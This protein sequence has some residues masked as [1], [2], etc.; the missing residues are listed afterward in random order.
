MA[1]S[2]SLMDW[3]PP[4]PE[5]VYDPYQGDYMPGGWPFEPAAKSA[6]TPGTFA[7][8]RPQ[9][10]L[11][12]TAK[13]VCRGL[14]S[15]GLTATAVLS[16]YTH[17][18][19]LTI[20]NIP[21]Y[22]V[23]RRVQQRQRQERL[24]RP[25]RQQRTPPTSLTDSPWQRAAG[26]NNGSLWEMQPSQEAPSSPAP[27][28]VAA[29]PQATASALPNIPPPNSRKIIDQF[30]PFQDMV[31]QIGATR[32]TRQVRRPD[33]RISK[34]RYQTAPVVRANTRR[35]AR[36]IDTSSTPIEKRVEE[37]TTPPTEAATLQTPY[38]EL[39]PADTTTP[40]PSSQSQED[41]DT[42]REGDSGTSILAVTRSLRSN[43][44]KIE[45]QGTRESVQMQGASTGK[46]IQTSGP[47]VESPKTPTPVIVVQETSSAVSA[48][49]Q[50]PIDTSLLSPPRVKNRKV[51][52]PNSST[53]NKAKLPKNPKTPEKQIIS[54]I[55]SPKSEFSSTCNISPELTLLEALNQAKSPAES[56]I[57][58]TC[59]VSPELTLLET[60]N[61]AKSPAESDISSAY[62]GTPPD[63]SQDG[64]FFNMIMA[65]GG[66]F[67]PER[68][69]NKPIEQVAATEP[70]VSE[71]TQVTV[72]ETTSNPVGAMAPEIVQAAAETDLTSHEQQG[73]AQSTPPEIAQNPAETTPSS[74]EQR[75]LE[76]PPSPKSVQDATMSTS[77][78][79]PVAIESNKAA[80]AEVNLVSDDQQVP[81]QSNE[82]ANV[83]SD[84]NKQSSAPHI[85]DVG[86]AEPSKSNPK[87]PVKKVQFIETP[88]TP[89]KESES[90][91]RAEIT[92]PEQKLA[93]LTLDDPY[94][95]ENPLPKASPHSS[96]KK[97]RITRA[98]AKRLQLLEEARNYGITPL[99]EEWEKKIQTALRQGHGGFKATDFTRVVPL[100]QGRGTDNWLNDEVINGYLKLVV[101]HGRQNDRPTQ[102][103]THHAFVSFFYNN[104]ESKGY[105]GVRRWASR[106][107]IGGKNLLETEQVFI[108]INS[109]MHWTLCVVSGK[110]KTITHYNSLGGNGRRYVQT[111]KEWVRQELGAAFKEEEWS[112]N[113]VGESPRQQNM[114]DCGVFTI[115]SARQIM[116]GLSPMSYGPEQ[117]LLQRRR[118]VAELLNGALLKSSE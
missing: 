35:P 102:V 54:N 37:P 15:L 85:E 30:V 52:T 83:I 2:S 31:W 105:D 25:R 16:Q 4:T 28:P 24:Q 39:K 43:K 40:S 29:P 107:K 110:N 88:V 61:Q 58:S 41:A 50:T 19:T 78:Q 60:L 75:A 12:P 9:T 53:R 6:P 101:A 64:R 21:T 70:A 67:S 11:L 20:V 103:P 46:R 98:E 47:S 36:S 68:K 109:G 44:R 56:D 86:K 72:S 27:V 113:A 32:T 99:T 89:E 74:D 17:N 93:T 1:D 63:L 73:M 49:A 48:K 10:G 104:L 112:L 65:G 57:S 114:D 51:S 84:T 111:V 76:E 23:V 117:I 33:T 71:P 79:Q 34:R 81:T 13:R 115:T 38:P 26:V 100:T 3:C 92:T 7:V 69:G 96:E 55:W 94:T 116:L 97:H 95:P 87:T 8:K 5:P 45:E 18:A 62:H 91:E 106:A 82:A 118:I 42:P 90:S 14:F 80:N 108:P 66:L 22:Y 77:D 59:N